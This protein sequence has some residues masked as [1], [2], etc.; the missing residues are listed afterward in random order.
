MRIVHLNERTGEWA[1]LLHSFCHI[2]SQGDTNVKMV[3]TLGDTSLI[4]F[5]F[6]MFS[7]NVGCK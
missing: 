6:Q 4:S 3:K 1:V 2:S 5:H 7:R